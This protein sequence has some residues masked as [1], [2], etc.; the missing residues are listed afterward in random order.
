MGLCAGFE[1][2]TWKSCFPLSVLSFFFFLTVV[3]FLFVC[4]FLLLLIFFDL[5]ISILIMEMEKL[6]E[7]GICL[8]IKELESTKR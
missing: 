5:L 3:N 1:V 2:S 4:L 6:S 7:L 8:L